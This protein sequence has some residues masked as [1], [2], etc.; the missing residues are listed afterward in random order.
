MKKFVIIPAVT[1]IAILLCSLTGCQNDAKTG[2]EFSLSVGQS[3]EITGEDL[4]ITFTEVSGDSRCPS[5]V[6][7]VWAGEV[8]CLMKIEA[9]GVKSDVEFVQS[10]GTDSYSRM[11]F[12]NYRYTFKVEP[13]PVSGQ[14][15]SDSEYRLLL[16][17]N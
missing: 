14:E 7:C 16:T 9:G 2:E 6:V 4:K 11:D 8:T 15:I 10:G 3:V 1:G 17:V 12:G 5:D 13:Y